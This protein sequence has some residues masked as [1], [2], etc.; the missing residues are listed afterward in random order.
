MFIKINVQIE[1]VSYREEKG[2][3]NCCEGIYFP[4][5]WLFIDI[6]NPTNFWSGKS[7]VNLVF[8]FDV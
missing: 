5:W 1:E 2:L 6:R 3:T 8:C 4:W 7:V